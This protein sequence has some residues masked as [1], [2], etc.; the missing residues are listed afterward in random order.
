M[1]SEDEY[2][3]ISGLQHYSFCP[4]QWAL[5]H[6]EQQWADNLRTIDG[7]ILHE[8]AHDD[9]FNEKRKGVIIT[10]AM[11][12]S[13]ALLGLSG[14]CDIVEFFPDKNG[15]SLYGK[16]QKYISIPIEYKRGSPKTDDCD[17][18]QLTAQA[19]CLEEMLCCEIQYGYIFYGQ[20]RRR[21]KIIF[22]EDVRE[23]VR[24]YSCQ[25]NKLFES[26][27]T[28]KVK[29][30]KACNAGSLKNICLPE[31]MQK[32]S[33]KEYIDKLTENNGEGSAE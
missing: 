23:K 18:L 1:Y 21:E 29:R 20:T 30:R 11:P 32:R 14:E 9:N 13:S 31:I 10:R 3:M 6:L 12:V 25:M 2:L 15:V 8:K 22:E 7:E 5:I 33:V 4:R 26:S 17:I 28:P 24:E 19:M 16:E 27:H